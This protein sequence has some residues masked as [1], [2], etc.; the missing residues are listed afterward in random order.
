MREKTESINK[1]LDRRARSRTLH[2]EDHSVFAIS[3]AIWMALVAAPL[4]I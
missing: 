2:W 3:S 1:V 4:R